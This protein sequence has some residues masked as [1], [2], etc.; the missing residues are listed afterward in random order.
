MQPPPGVFAAS[1]GKIPDAVLR[2]PNGASR[3]ARVDPSAGAP[4][5]R[6]TLGD[7]YPCCDNGGME[8]SEFS[9]SSPAPVLPGAPLPPGAA[10]PGED[11]FGEPAR[12]TGGAGNLRKRIG[13]ALA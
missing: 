4:S 13:G 8:N 10:H 11:P 2:S 3:A 6:M 9:L 12:R 1:S 7:A 5:S